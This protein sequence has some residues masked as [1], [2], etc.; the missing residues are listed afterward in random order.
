MR[1]KVY[2]NR[3]YKKHQFMLITILKSKIH[4]AKITKSD[5]NYQGS[6]E[7]DEDLMDASGIVEY[8]KVLVANIS[9]GNRFETYVI[10]GERGTGVIALNGAASRLGELGDKI[11]IFAFAQ[12]EEDKLKDYKP[13]IVL[14]DENNAVS[15]II[16]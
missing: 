10:T 1:K 11:I 12:V 9:N 15:E 16:Y 6:I 7:I 8:E 3:I 2:R 4:S 14:V 13:K 5:L